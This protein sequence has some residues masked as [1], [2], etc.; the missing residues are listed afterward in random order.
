MTEG[1]E[2]SKRAVEERLGIDEGASGGK[3]EA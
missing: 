1:D 2:D 3:E